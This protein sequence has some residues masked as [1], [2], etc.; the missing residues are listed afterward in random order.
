MN[1]NVIVTIGKD[2]EVTA[3]KLLGFVRKAESITPQ[4]AAGLGVVLSAVDKALSDADAVAQSP[5]QALNISF[6]QQ[7][8]ADVKA[9][10]PDIKAFIA[11]LG[12]KF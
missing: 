9:V 7:T 12:I 4:A 6:D 3:E 10:W 5:T 1:S 11:E 8:L 2:I